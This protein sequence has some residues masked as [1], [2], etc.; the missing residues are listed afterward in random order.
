MFRL[1]LLQKTEGGLLHCLSPLNL[2]VVNRKL[3]VTS[4]RLDPPVSGSVVIN[5]LSKMSARKI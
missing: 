1:K 5:G 3:K 2:L 4:K